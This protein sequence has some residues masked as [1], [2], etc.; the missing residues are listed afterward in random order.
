MKENAMLS[1]RFQEP[2]GFTWGEFENASGA[3]IRYGSLQPQGEPKG[4]IV[5]ATGFQEMTEMYFET[6]RDLTA[7]G[8]AVWTM[9][10]HGQGGSERFIKSNPQKMHNNGYDEHIATLDQFAKEIVKKSKGPL[11]LMGHSMGGH[12]SL[13]YLKEHP[14]DG[15]YPDT[16]LPQTGGEAA[17]K[18]CRAVSCP[19]MLCPRRTAR[20][21][22]E[23]G[24]QRHR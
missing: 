2:A 9:D 10:W 3:R 11:I 1:A 8:F 24:C 5:L 19:E 12:I 14:G 22:R 20:L 23:A 15:R 17:G 6:M 21:G 7:R 13:R 18:R 16:G 4:T